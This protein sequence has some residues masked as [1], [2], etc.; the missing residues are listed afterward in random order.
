[1]PDL[2]QASNKKHPNTHHRIKSLLFY[3]IFFTFH[4]SFPCRR[5]FSPFLRLTLTYRVFDVLK[6]PASGVWVGRK[7]FWR[8]SLSWCELLHQIFTAPTS[9]LIIQIMLKCGEASTQNRKFRNVN[10]L[11]HDA[12]LPTPLLSRIP[13]KLAVC[14]ERQHKIPPLTH[15][16]QRRAQHDTAPTSKLLLFGVEYPQNVNTLRLCGCKRRES[17]SW[18]NDEFFIVTTQPNRLSS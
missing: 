4:L 14:F 10:I 3:W 6:A 18:K 16:H 7:G 15:T 8:L 11:S 17:L 9:Y 13:V 12:P 2:R 5:R 1:M